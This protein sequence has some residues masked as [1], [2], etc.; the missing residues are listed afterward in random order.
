MSRLSIMKN[1]RIATRHHYD[2]T[3]SAVIYQQVKEHLIKVEGSSQRWA[4][5]RDHTPQLMKELTTLAIS[6]PEHFSN[7]SRQRLLGSQG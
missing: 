5:K 1:C 2:I 7:I 4:P 3:V 6:T